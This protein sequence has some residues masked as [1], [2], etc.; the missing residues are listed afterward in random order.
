MIWY[1]KNKFA[2]VDDSDLI[3]NLGKMI[4]QLEK[5]VETWDWSG[6]KIPNPE[7]VKILKEI[8]GLEEEPSDG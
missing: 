1:P 5:V 4:Q 8:A 2:V 6:T 3:D 7:D